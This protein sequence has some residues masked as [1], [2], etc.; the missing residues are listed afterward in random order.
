MLPF[1]GRHGDPTDKTESDIDKYQKDNKY[2]CGYICGK[3]PLGL[4]SE[5]SAFLAFGMSH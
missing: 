2:T 4:W 1:K 3:G 5:W